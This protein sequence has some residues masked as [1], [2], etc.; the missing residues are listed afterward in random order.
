MG[1]QF[2]ANQNNINNRRQD[3]ADLKANQ[4]AI[5]VGKMNANTANMERQDANSRFDRRLQFDR[6]KNED[7]NTLDL[8]KAMFLSNRGK[9]AK[10]PTTNF[11]TIDTLDGTRILPITTNPD[12]SYQANS[13]IDPMNP[14]ANTGYQKPTKRPVDTGLVDP[15]TRRPIYQDENGR[16][17]L[18]SN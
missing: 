14:T 1:N 8:Y 6:A 2:S 7:S 4:A 12:G 17:Y 11:K 16:K 18:M 9:D 10:Q 3:A 5:K 13:L 15:K